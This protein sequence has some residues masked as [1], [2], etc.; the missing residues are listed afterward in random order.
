MDTEAQIRDYLADNLGLIEPELTL[1]DK[2]YPL[3]NKDS[4]VGYVDILAKDRFG[5]IVIIELKKVKT[6]QKTRFTNFTSM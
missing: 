3:K 1:L 6:L 4:V 2:E 5:N